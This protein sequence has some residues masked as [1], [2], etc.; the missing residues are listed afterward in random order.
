MGIDLKMNKLMPGF[1]GG[2]CSQAHSERELKNKVEARSEYI[3]R[4]E[5]NKEENFYEI[6]RNRGYDVLNI[7]IPVLKNGK[8]EWKVDMNGVIK[9]ED[10]EILRG[11]GYI[12]YMNKP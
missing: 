3:F 6:L 11:A 7:H 9:D 12:F 8:F 1:D 4:E 5:A 10:A 2:D